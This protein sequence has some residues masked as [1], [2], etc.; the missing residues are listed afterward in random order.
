MSAIH[1]GHCC[2]VGLTISDNARYTAY[3]QPLPSM[4]KRAPLFGQTACGTIPVPSWLRRRP[5]MPRQDSQED[6]QE[7]NSDWHP[8]SHP[9]TN[10]QKDSES[11]REI[12][13]HN[14][15]LPEHQSKHNTTPHARV[16]SG[17]H[18]HSSRESFVDNPRRAFLHNASEPTQSP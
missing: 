8:G 1:L 9:K 6:P 11:Y 7:D 16:P 5:A 17:S 15:H 2:Q 12:V 13:K 3:Q 14:T 4:Q 18:L 10:P